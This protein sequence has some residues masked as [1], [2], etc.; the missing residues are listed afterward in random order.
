MNHPEQFQE[1]EVQSLQAFILFANTLAE[2]DALP[3]EPSEMECA[4]RTTNN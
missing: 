2:L 4:F 3:D 1:L